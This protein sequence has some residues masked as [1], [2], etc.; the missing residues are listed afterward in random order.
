MKYGECSTENAVRRVVGRVRL[1]D[2]KTKGAARVSM[3]GRGS[4]PAAGRY[5]KQKT[6]WGLVAVGFMFPG[7]WILSAFLIFPPYM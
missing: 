5:S 1:V 3:S 6:A 4:M 2:K 7:G